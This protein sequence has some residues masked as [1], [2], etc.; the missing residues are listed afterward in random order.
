ME[1]EDKGLISYIGNYR[2]PWPEFDW[3]EVNFSGQILGYSA[4]ILLEFCLY[5]LQ[6]RKTQSNVCLPFLIEEFG[7]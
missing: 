2:K 5:L 1:I 6:G 7:P 4:N 3:R